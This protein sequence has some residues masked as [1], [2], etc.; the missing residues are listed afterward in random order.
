MTKPITEEEVDSASRITMAQWEVMR[1]Q[2]GRTTKTLAEMDDLTDEGVFLSYQQRLSQSTALNQ[3]VVIEKSRR[4][5][6]T[7][8]LAADGVLTSASERSQGGMD[9]LYIGYNLEMAREFIDTC[10]EWAN[11]F[12]SISDEIEEFI[13]VDKDTDGNKLEIQ[14]FRIR[15]QSGFAITALTSS[16][17]SLRGRQGF[18]IIDEA[19]FHDDLRELIKAAMALL[20]WGGKV[21]VIST[22]DGEENEFNKLIGDIRA[23][24]LDYE[25]IRIDFDDAIKDGLYERV[26]QRL[27]KEWSAKAEAE[28]REKIISTYGDGADEELY[29]IPSRSGGAY[30]SGALIRKNQQPAPVLRWECDNNFVHLPKGERKARTQDWLEE[31]V[32]PILESLDPNLRCHAGSDFGRVSDLTVIWPL[33]VQRTMDFVTP[34]LI[35]L[36]NVPFENQQQIFIYVF[37]RLPKF[38]TAALDG[39]GNGAHLAELVQQHFG[40]EHIEIVLFSQSWYRENFPVL[41][42]SFEDEEMTAPKDDDIYNDFR[43]VKKIRNVPQV[44]SDKRTAELA[45][46]GR[47]RHGDAAIAAVLARF[48]VDMET[49]SYA[50]ETMQ[51]LGEEEPDDDDQFDDS[52]LYN[53]RDDGLF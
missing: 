52:E 3:V 53:N 4:V 14:A 27:G 20:I 22:H 46:K 18:V 6:A 21:C 13:F 39:G 42:Q 23:G 8:A 7:W 29:C 11:Q 28:W 15:F 10:G 51:S 36:R 38:S 5:G 25:L 1:E 17:R 43:A 12:N 33:Q 40:A 34:F 48:A 31:Y 35:E 19:A 32:R 37:M 9:T 47:K 24:K 16:P 45:S 41:K 49:I 50:F 26:C 44:P 2:T 30:F